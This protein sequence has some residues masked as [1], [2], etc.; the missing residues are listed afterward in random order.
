MSERKWVREE[1]RKGMSEVEELW[2]KKMIQELNP[3]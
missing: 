3:F 1:E 2:R